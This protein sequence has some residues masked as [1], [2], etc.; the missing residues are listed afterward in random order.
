VPDALVELGRRFVEELAGLLELRPRLRLV[1][2]CCDT[3]NCG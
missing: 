3:Q 1:A 2:Y